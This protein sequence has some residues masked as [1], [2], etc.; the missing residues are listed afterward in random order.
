MLV[1]R[2]K[3]I[4]YSECASDVQITRCRFQSANTLEC[5]S[6]SGNSPHPRFV[7][8]ALR[9]KKSGCLRYKSFSYLIFKLTSF[10]FLFDIFLCVRAIFAQPFVLKLTYANCENL[11]SSVIAQF[12]LEIK[13]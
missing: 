12:T 7:Y 8:F 1:S 3:I 6:Y 13:N 10:A 2:K 4:V 5:R 9:V 11:T